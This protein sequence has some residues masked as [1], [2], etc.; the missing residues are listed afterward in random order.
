MRCD[1]CAPWIARGYQIGPCLRCQ[2]LTEQHERFAE[3]MAFAESLPSR[4]SSNFRIPPTMV[5]A[6]VCPE[7]ETLP[8]QVCNC[9]RVDHGRLS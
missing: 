6:D 8:P 3:Q 7:R 5:V 4:F 1:D 9:K 2:D